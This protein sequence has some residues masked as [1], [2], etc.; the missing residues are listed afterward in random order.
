[1]GFDKAI[2]EVLEITSEINLIQEEIIAAGVCI[3]VNFFSNST[4]IIE[5]FNKNNCSSTKEIFLNAIKG[6]MGGDVEKEVE[7][8][9][10]LNDSD[11]F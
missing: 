7:K 8:Y 11:F 1:M 5:C 10:G 6:C 2:T 4:E 3:D 9:L